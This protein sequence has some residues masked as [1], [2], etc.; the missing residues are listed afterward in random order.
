[1]GGLV[2]KGWKLMSTKQRKRIWAILAIYS[3]LI[4]YF[5]FFGFGRPTAAGGLQEYQFNLMP[6]TL[7]LKFP[8]F[9]DL[10]YFHIW[11]FNL[12]N[13]VAF[14]PFGI[15]IPLLLRLKFPTFIALFF[16][17]ILILETVQML[18]FLGS[19]DIDDALVNT[20]GAS[21]GFYAYE[22]GSR[23]TDRGKRAIAIL[24][25]AGIFSFAVI[26]FSELLSK[27]AAPVEGPEQ[28]LSE[29]GSLPYEPDQRFQI[30]SERIEPAKNLY[31]GNAEGP[32]EFVYQLDGKDILL[33]LN[34]GIPA[35]AKS[36]TGQI[37]ISVDGKEVDT[38]SVYKE[39]NS[40]NAS[41]TAMEKV[42]ELVITIEGEVMLWDVTFKE[43]GHWWSD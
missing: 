40:A 9:S 13:L 33:S 6:H 7:A 30:G 41:E 32:T 5:M 3:L 10:K 34:Y 39:P 24:L 36:D 2:Q 27:M 42:N 1:M 20:L 22:L 29:A 21:I 11:F 19:F 43:M 25:W 37:H 16:S 28:V 14:I 12:G 17:G 26:G 4:V 23:Y 18:T 35:A 38:Y 15:L 31:S 8:N